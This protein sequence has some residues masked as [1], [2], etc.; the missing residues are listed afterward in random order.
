MSGGKRMARERLIPLRVNETEYRELASAARSASARGISSFIR[1]ES[2]FMV[3]CGPPRLTSAKRSE[4]VK[5]AWEVLRQV[6]LA[7][8]LI[9]DLKDD[10]RKDK[11]LEAKEAIDTSSQLLTTLEDILSTLDT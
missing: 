7:Q 8:A 4:L 6:S 1:E 10:F 9:R 5:T 3:R 11:L 2:L